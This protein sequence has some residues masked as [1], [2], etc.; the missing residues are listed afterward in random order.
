MSLETTL[1]LVLAAAILVAALLI[2]LV[3]WGVFRVLRLVFRGGRGVV[4]HYRQPRL[5]DALPRVTLR[6]RLAPVARGAL[7]PSRSPLRRVRGGV[8]R[9][10][11]RVVA[12]WRAR[13]DELTRLLSESP[14]MTDH[15]EVF[16]L[17]DARDLTWDPLD[18]A[19]VAAGGRPLIDPGFR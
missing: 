15:A 9:S 18:D 10:R 16:Q 14:A 6:E 7:A 19:R 3:L 11:H 17:D 13:V 8:A 1:T 12:T 5:E 2:Q 4:R